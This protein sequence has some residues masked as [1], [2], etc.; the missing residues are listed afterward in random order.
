[1]SI[2]VVCGDFRRSGKVVAPAF[3]QKLN[4]QSRMKSNGEVVL[5]S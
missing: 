2:M 5:I 4:L 1:M 3:Y